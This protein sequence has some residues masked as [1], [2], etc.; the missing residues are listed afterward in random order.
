MVSGT[1]ALSSAFASHRPIAISLGPGETKRIDMAEVLGPSS[2]GAVGGLSLSLPGKEL[3][4][5]TQIVFDEVTGLAAMMKMFDRE[6]DD[7]PKGRVLLAPMMALSQ[8]DQGLGFPNGTQLLPRIFLRN[9]GPAPTQVAMSVDWRSDAKSGELA[10]SPLA[11]SPGEVKVINLAD[12]QKSGQI[13][14]DASWGTLKL[15]YTGRRADLVAVA[16]SYDKSNRYGLQTPFSEDLSRMWAGGMW[17]VDPTHN[18]FI[19]TG[20]GGTEA[21]TAEVTLFYNSG[22]SK[23]RMEKMLSPGQQLW[24]DVG[25]LVHDQVPDSDGHTLPPDTMTGSYELRDLDH[26]Y[27][28]QLYEGKLVI[29]K[30]YGHAAYGCGSC[31]GYDAVVLDPDPFGGPPG[32]ENDDYI[33]ANDTCSGGQADVTGGGYSWASSDT[34]VATLPNRTLHT[35]GVGSATGSTLVQLQR[36]NPPHCLVTVFGPT[37]PV[38]VM[39]TITSIS[40]AQGLVGT[41]INVTVTGTGFASGATVSAGSN[42]S[43]SSVSV[44]SS[45]QITATFTPTNSSSAGGDQAVTV[46]SG[47]QK[48]NSKNF[49]DQIPT[50]FQFVT[51][52]GAPGGKGPIV[53]V[54]NGNVV[55]LNGQVI[56]S[57]YCGV[58]ENFA[59]EILDQQS[60]PLLNGAATGTEVFTNISVPPGPT[61]V[62]LAINFATQAWN[63][64]QAWKGTYP[65]FCPTNNDNQALDYSMTMKIG[66]TVY[67]L[68][69]TVH[70]TK[71]NFNGTLNVTAAITVP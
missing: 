43:V 42:I 5:A 22:T 59:Y 38:S 21:T 7:Q 32:I 52:A 70:Y 35:V 37:Q 33:Y 11:L 24:L 58:Y 31:C 40:P 34:A 46:T 27:V 13:P 30:T 23:Y 65:K 47:G 63:D 3:I 1:L 67:P 54:T 16:V 25:H 20:N 57:N 61:P 44:K 66:S 2:I 26:A 53:P 50:H 15:A 8:P 28:G 12:D 10:L 60:N 68:V 55:A 51:V 62:V 14:P 45:T 49:F 64:T 69:T 71:G 19:T 29:D 9:A 18:T 4:S 17:H 39:P 6:P 56:Q 36:A 48:S 41:A